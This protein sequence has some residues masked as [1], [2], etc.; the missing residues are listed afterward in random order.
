MPAP[1]LSAVGSTSTAATVP[2][3]P[4][5]VGIV[6]GR[7]AAASRNG[8]G[9]WGSANTIAAITGAASVRSASTERE[10]EQDRER[11]REREREELRESHSNTPLHFPPLS[12]SVSSSNLHSQGQSEDSNSRVPT[13]VLKRSASSTTNVATL[14]AST[15]AA[16]APAP[17]VDPTPVA[18]ASTVSAATATTT[19]TTAATVT[20]VVLAAAGAVKTKPKTA[21]EIAREAAAEKKAA[22]AAVRAEKLALAAQSAAATTSADPSSTAPANSASGEGESKSSTTTTTSTAP[23][24]APTPKLSAKQQMLANKAE[25]AAKAQAAALA[26]QEAREAARAAKESAKAAAREHALALHN[27]GMSKKDLKHANSAG[28]SATTSSASAANTNT[29]T[30]ETLPPA[31]DSTLD[32]SILQQVASPV[33]SMLESPPE[34][35][36]V[37]GFNGLS[38]N[39]LF[40]VPVSSL[41]CSVWSNILRASNEDLSI[42]PYGV[43][44]VPVSELLDLML[45]PVDAMLSASPCWPRP[46]AYYTQG[47]QAGGVT[48]SPAGKH[49]HQRSANDMALLPPM[50]QMLP[51]S[52][53]QQQHQQHSQ[54]QGREQE[55]TLSPAEQAALAQRRSKVTA[56]LQAITTEAEE[57]V[58]ASVASVPALAP[59]PGVS[60][61]AAAA[62]GPAP[63][64]VRSNGRTAGPAHLPPPPGVTP[65]VSAASTGAA[66]AGPSAGGAAVGATNMNALRQLFPGVKMSV[67]TSK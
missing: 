9:T 23:A 12:S 50:L 44:E 62:R 56:L 31:H 57:T 33:A 45:P 54:L 40:P 53:T 60:V 6:L 29:N 18:S 65:V 11:E 32:L 30:S 15:S 59:P 46:L 51:S 41:S 24:I 16:S 28:A 10:R 34:Y 20:P 47:M 3:V 66:S 37:Q 14:S 22:A 43:L 64:A 61:P 1:G 13:A 39:S 7:P 27:G 2:A 67:S 42:N 38:V 25:K 4:P 63:G 21:K 5:G 48:F 58:A 49:L 36:L 26:A 19:T 55:V 17:V 35:A 52:V 8:T